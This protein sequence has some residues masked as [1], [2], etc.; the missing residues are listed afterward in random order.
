MFRP[1]ANGDFNLNGKCGTF[2][3]DIVKI[4]DAVM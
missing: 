2:I 1:V 3:N 4:I